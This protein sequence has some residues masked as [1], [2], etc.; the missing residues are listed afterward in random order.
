MAMIADADLIF[1]VGAGLEEFLDDLLWKEP[2]GM[3]GWWKYRTGSSCSN[4]NMKVK[5]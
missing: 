1:M 5:M 4:S 3:R 2:A